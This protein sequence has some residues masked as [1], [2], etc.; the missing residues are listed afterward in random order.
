MSHSTSKSDPRS[1]ALQ[2]GASCEPAELGPNMPKDVPKLSKKHLGS[3]PRDLL[4]LWRVC[5]FVC[6]RSWYPPHHRVGSG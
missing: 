6:A 5:M 4:A 2:L 3:S 1:D